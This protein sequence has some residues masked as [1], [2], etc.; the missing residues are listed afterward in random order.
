METWHPLGPEKIVPPR[1]APICR[2]PAAENAFRKNDFDQFKGNIDLT[3]EDVLGLLSGEIS[4]YHIQHR[5][6]RIVFEQRVARMLLILAPYPTHSLLARY[7]AYR[8]DSSYHRREA[9]LHA[10]ESTAIKRVLDSRE[11]IP[12]HPRGP[13]KV[14]RQKLAEANRGQNKSKNR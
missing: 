1:P 6:E 14:R 2:Y 7:R 3:P 13:G 5:R 9:D 8:W 12:R 10:V 4:E 11:H